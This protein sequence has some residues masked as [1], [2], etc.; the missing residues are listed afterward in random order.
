VHFVFLYKFIERVSRIL[1]L[2]DKQTLQ[3]EDFHV[4]TAT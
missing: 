1:P 4:K 3:C 2:G